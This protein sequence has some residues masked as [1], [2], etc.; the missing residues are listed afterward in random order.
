MSSKKPTPS[1]SEETNQN[2]LKKRG[3]TLEMKNQRKTRYKSSF[4]AGPK[5]F[6]KNI[7]EHTSNGTSNKLSEDRLQTVSLE[8]MNKYLTIELTQR[9]L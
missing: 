3:W 6:R 9:H 4:I 5:N 1:I 8:E 7:L 2:M